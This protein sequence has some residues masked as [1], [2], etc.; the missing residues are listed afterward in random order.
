MVKKKVL[1]SFQFSS[2]P[3]NSL[4]KCFGG[5]HVVIALPTLSEKFKK[6][7]TNILFYMA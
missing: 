4:L 7:E 5:K 1:E 3:H 6:L 2:Y